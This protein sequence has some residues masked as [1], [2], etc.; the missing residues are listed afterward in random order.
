MLFYST[1]S[2]HV[3]GVLPFVSYNFSVIRSHIFIYTLVFFFII[4]N[5]SSLTPRNL[6]L[7]YILFT[8]LQPPSYLLVWSEL[9]QREI[10]YQVNVNYNGWICISFLPKVKTLESIYIQI[11][12]IIM[13]VCSC[14]FTAP[15]LPKNSLSL[16]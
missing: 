8:I 2:L 3:T 6:S 16:I 13:L 15:L 9:D 14:F 10:L 11:W 1:W 12:I 7:K 5:H 4:F